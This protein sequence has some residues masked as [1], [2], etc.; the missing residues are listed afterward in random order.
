MFSIFT[1]VELNTG[2]ARFAKTKAKKHTQRTNWT[3]SSRIITLLTS[4]S[5]IDWQCCVW[6]V[7]EKPPCV[8]EN[9]NVIAEQILSDVVNQIWLVRFA[10]LIVMSTVPPNSM[11]LFSKRTST[12][13]QWRWRRPK[14]R[15][16]LLT[17]GKY[18]EHDQRQ[19][20]YQCT[21]TRRTASTLTMFCHLLLCI[22]QTKCFGFT[23]ALEM[24]YTDYKLCI[25]EYI[26]NMICLMM[27]MMV[28]QHI[29]HKWIKRN[30][31]NNSIERSV[32]IAKNILNWIQMHNL[33]IWRI[34][35]AR[36]TLWNRSDSSIHIEWCLRRI[37]E[38]M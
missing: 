6:A 2:F 13:Q 9:I 30:S 11:C 21:S 29:I 36:Q 31:G 12:Q 28:N 5:T 17:Y 8:T 37:L 10:R 27:I 19:Q 22:T 23:L 15:I 35:G 16:R 3:K 24:D 14:K 7:T 25:T 1:Q 20:I 33:G 4:T 18:G 32:G 38:R 26:R 34:I